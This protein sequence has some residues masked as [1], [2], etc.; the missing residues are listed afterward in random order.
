MWPY[1]TSPQSLKHWKKSTK[2]ISVYCQDISTR[3]DQLVLLSKVLDLEDQIDFALEE[4][5]DEHK[6]VTDQIESRDT[7][8]PFNDLHEKLLNDE[9]R[10]LSIQNSQSFPVTANVVNN[11][12]C[13]C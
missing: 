5:P 3:V 12:Y 6:Q 4:L 8:L 10:I 7:P 13:P 11:G 2:T 9:A 1:Q